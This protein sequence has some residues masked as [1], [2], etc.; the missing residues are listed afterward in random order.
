MTAPPPLLTVQRSRWLGLAVLTLPVILTSMD[1]TI[2]HMAIPTITR[3]LAPSSSQTLWILDAYGF[4]LAGLLIVMGNIGDRIGRRRLLLIGAAIF[5][6]ASAAA[7]FAP[8]AEVLIA[9]RALMGVGGATLMPST[10]SLIRNM[11]ADPTER[12]KAIGIWTASL[13]VGI[14]LGPI[15]GGLLLESFWWGSV[16]IVNVPIIVVLLVVAPALVPEYRSPGSTRLD[17]LSVTLSFA[18]ILPIVWAIKTAAEELTMTAP[19]W[20]ALGVG[21]LAGV[22]FIVRQGRISGPLVDLGLFADPRFTGAILAGGMAMW[23]W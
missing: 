11:F 7:A 13:S 14:A 8:T 4:L 12:T 19:S 10:L 3:E 23:R 6:A 9:A 16:F 2:L 22:V 20:V 17:V 21:V 18:A 5:G 15:V 1:V